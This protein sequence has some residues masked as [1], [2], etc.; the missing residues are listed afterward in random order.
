MAAHVSRARTVH[1]SVSDVTK[2]VSQRLPPHLR[3]FA[4]LFCC[5][6]L[7]Q[8]GHHFNPRPVGVGVGGEMVPHH[9]S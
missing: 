8:I 9:K 4:V 3:F 1:S 5:G 2:V 7:K 6:H